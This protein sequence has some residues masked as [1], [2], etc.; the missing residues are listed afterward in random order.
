MPERVGPN[1]SLAVWEGYFQALRDAGGSV[2][3]EVVDLRFTRP[4]QSELS[5]LIVYNVLFVEIQDRLDANPALFAEHIIL[6]ETPH[7]LVGRFGE[8]IPAGALLNLDGHHTNEV[9]KL[10]A[11]IQHTNLR[12]GNVHFHHVCGQAFN[13]RQRVLVIKGI[14][15]L[16][17]VDLALRAGAD[18]GHGMTGGP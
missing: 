3:E 16:Q 18:S 13:P 14:D 8:R 6:V 10:C 17:A 2:A 9:L 15:P 4:L 7:D 5:G 12:R 11:R 1:A